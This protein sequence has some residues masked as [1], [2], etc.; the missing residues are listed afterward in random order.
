MGA[1]A[2][3]GADRAADPTPSDRWFTACV[4]HPGGDVSKR[5]GSVVSWLVFLIVVMLWTVYLRPVALG[6]ST[7]LVGVAGIS[8][9]PVMHPGD[10]AFV[11]RETSYQVGDIIAFQ[12]QAADAPAIVVHRIVAIDGGGRFRVQGD[13]NG[14]TDPWTIQHEDVIG[15]LRIRLPLAGALVGAMHA[16]RP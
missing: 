2:S 8:M 7:T 10:L 16:L 14:R 13:N 15:R 4:P 12:P 1:V 9:E 11:R 6:G 3:R 5:P